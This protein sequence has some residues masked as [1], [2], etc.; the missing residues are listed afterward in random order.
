MILLYS[1]D[2]R[3]SINILDVL[4]NYI[5]ICADKCYTIDTVCLKKPKAS[6]KGRL[7]MNITVLEARRFVSSYGYARPRTVKDYEIDIEY[8]QNREYTCNGITRR[9]SRGD[10]LVRM[11]SDVVS[12]VGRQETYTLTLDFSGR[13]GISA[14]SRNIAGE[15][16]KRAH[17]LLTDELPPVIRPRNPNA[18][19][20]IYK[21]L[22]TATVPNGEAAKLL[23]MEI[24]Y[25]LN[26]EYAHERYKSL[27]PKES[28]VTD[29]AIAYMEE[30]LAEGITLNDLA[31]TA[32]LEKSYFVRLF[33]KNTGK[34]PCDMLSQMRLDRAADLV[35]LTNMKISD[36]AASV[37]YNTSSFFISAYKNRFGITPEAHRKSITEQQKG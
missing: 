37:G 24:L 30:H 28:D 13:E 12:S 18:L 9:L 29:K 22:A 21:K 33:R 25:M 35:A 1:L 3:L 19:F 27:K 32:N 16:Q 26:A 4:Y 36:V 34:T 11:P 31:A 5:D 10:V 20:E 6:L 15:I 2:I 7:K 17:S 23:V 14:Y 8:S